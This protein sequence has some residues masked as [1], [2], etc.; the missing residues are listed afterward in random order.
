MS[1]LLALVLSADA[2]TDEVVSLLRQGQD[3]AALSAS[4]QAV[5]QT[6][7]DVEAHELLIDLLVH[8]GLAYQA[9][10]AYRAFKNDNDTAMGWYLFGRAA[11]DAEE[12]R[13]AYTL[14]L[15]KDET[16]ARGWMGLASVDRAQGG[17]ARA[18]ERYRKALELDPSLSEAWAGLA[19]LLVQQ[20]RF[21][22]ALEVTRRATESVPDDPEG[23]LAGAALDP[24]NARAWLEE[25]VKHVP[26][27]PRLLHAVAS[28]RIDDNDLAAAR[29]ALEKAV[30][31]DPTIQQV[32]ADLEV[33]N[34]IDAKR[35]DLAGHGMLA[36][37][38]H[39]SS[40]APVAAL[41]TLDQLVKNYPDCYLVWLGRGHLYAEQDLTVEAEADL[42]KALELN[43]D[44]SDA[45]GALGLLLLNDQKP[46]E[47]LPLLES[48][49]ASRPEDISLGVSVGLAK[50]N[51][52]GVNAGVTHL[53]RVAEAN[54][55]DVA[56]V[57]A[58]VSVL[59]QAGRPDAAYTVLD[60]A[61]ERYPHP[62]LLL[63]FAAA[64]KDMGKND[65][66]AATLRELAFI[67]GDDKYVHMAQELDP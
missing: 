6:P 25:G 44:S 3:A 47:A 62:T 58:L 9:E 43:P 38:R 30:E 20:E 50:A 32:R 27:E 29:V 14:S 56:P 16:Y 63:A 5:V 57:M 10:N 33:L 48:A 51:V 65:K 8:L 15:A 13:E 1:L 31:V 22:E 66:A 60:R 34:E 19:G 55:N 17:L 11:L 54:P 26:D 67:T 49:A 61:I 18:E 23:W 2:N 52:Q 7:G 24:Q 35:F 21:D 45:Q 12:A 53:A 36:R 41:D 64:A 59:T 4:R 28:A 39:L 42:R 46:K 37:A 40:A